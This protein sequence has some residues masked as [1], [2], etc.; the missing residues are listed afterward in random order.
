[1]IKISIKKNNNYIEAVSITGHAMYDDFGKDI[2]CSSVSSIVITTI[3]AIERI[4]KDSISYT[5]EPFSVKVL[6]NDEITRVLIENMISLLEELGSQYHE[7]IK[8]L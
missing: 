3:N 5:E 1:M 4:N 2:V 8:F 7:N 6:K